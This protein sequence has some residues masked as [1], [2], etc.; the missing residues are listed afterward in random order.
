VR[1]KSPTTFIKKEEWSVQY[2]QGEKGGEQERKS[3]NLPNIY[4][5]PMGDELANTNNYPSV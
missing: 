4:N 1:Q 3:Y 2:Q 5:N